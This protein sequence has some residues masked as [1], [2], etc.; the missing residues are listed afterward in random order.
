MTVTE[1]TNFTEVAEMTVAELDDGN[2]EPTDFTEVAELDDG[3]W[4]L[5]LY[6]GCWIGW[7]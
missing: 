7:R 1:L 2:S 4:T 3:I 6:R 5:W